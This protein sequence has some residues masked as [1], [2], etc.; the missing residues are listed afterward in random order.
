[1]YDICV[2]DYFF[3]D[4]LNENTNYDVLFKLKKDISISKNCSKGHGIAIL[5]LINTISIEAKICLVPINSL[6]SCLD[7]IEILYKIISENLSKIINIS[8]G[9][10][11]ESVTDKVIEL[12]NDILNLAKLNNII[13]VSS[14]SN[15]EYTTIPNCLNDTISVFNDEYSD[16]DIKYYNSRFIFRKVSLFVNW[17][18][19]RKIWVN[20]NSFY[21]AIATSIIWNDIEKITNHIDVQYYNFEDILKNIKF[22]YKLLEGD[23]YV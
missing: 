17:I 5:D 9:F 15:D 18:N 21:T 12:F 19:G 4:W 14:D 2:I 8:F 7:I 11:K 3:E 13:I 20:G 6:Y 23:I 22:S 10:L 1:M 16:F